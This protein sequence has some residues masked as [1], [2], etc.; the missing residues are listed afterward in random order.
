MIG[1]KSQ[2][3]RP[4][5]EGSKREQGRWRW[6]MGSMQDPAESGWHPSD[7]ENR[8]RGWGWGWN[9]GRNHGSSVARTQGE[10]CQG[11]MRQGESRQGE[12]SRGKVSRGEAGSGKVGGAKMAAANAGGGC[13]G[14]GRVGLGASR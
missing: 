14:R 3:D 13:L 6:S 2:R 12:V 10:L 8:D 11:K 7:L 4:T 1:R 9:V 5:R